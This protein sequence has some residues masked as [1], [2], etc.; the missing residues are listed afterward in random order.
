MS[1]LKFLASLP[2]LLAITGFVVYYF[3]KHSR[4]GDRITLDILAKLRRDHPDKLPAGSETL[5]PAALARLVLHDANLRARVSEQDFTLLRDAL[6]HQFVISALVYGLCA[7]VFLAGVGLY[8]YVSSRPPPLSISSITASSANA[9]AEGLAV[10]LDDLRIRWLA[11]GTP[12]D[13]AV[14]L[15]NMRTQLRTSAKTVRSSESQ[16]VFSPDDYRSILTTRAHGGENRLRVVV[17]TAKSLFFSPE[18]AVYVGTTILAVHIA[19]LR[20]KI[21]GV[22][23]NE[24][25]PYYDFDAKL[26]IWVSA[27]GKAPEPLTIGGAIP[28]GKNDFK[29]NPALHYQWNTVKL[30]Y[31]GPDDLDLTRFRTH[32]RV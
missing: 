4:S 1:A 16:L 26:L 2:A 10:D 31:F 9:A 5:T 22:I 8:T 28:Y 3:L 15:E 24:A 12:E 20:I 18:F 19:P 11:T 29:L 21:M 7:V 6:R 32:P 14:S 23:D 25:I 13:V 30:T 27:P 17:Q